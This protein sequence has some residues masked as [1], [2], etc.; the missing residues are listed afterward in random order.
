MWDDTVTKVDGQLL[1]S[2]VVKGDR[3]LTDGVRAGL[4]VIR[5]NAP[6]F[7]DTVYK[8][9]TR[10]GRDS[11][12]TREEMFNAMNDLSTPLRVTFDPSNLVNTDGSGGAAAFVALFS[13]FTGVRYRVDVV[14]IGVVGISG[15]IYEVRERGP[16]KRGFRQNIEIDE[17]KSFGQGGGH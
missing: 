14:C 11:P 4:L 17:T 13:L 8:A 9:Y 1:F 16:S 15:S 2:H 3:L 12:C 5:R 10:I 6:T 7:I